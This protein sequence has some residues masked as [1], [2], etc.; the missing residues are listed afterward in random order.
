MR[1][2]NEKKLSEISEQRI[3]AFIETIILHIEQIAHN[4]REKPLYL[5]RRFWLTFFLSASIALAGLLYSHVQKVSETKLRR[6]ARLSEICHS[7]PER[8]SN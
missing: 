7:L 4:G 2:K 6:Q 3:T 1:A 5:D 8:E